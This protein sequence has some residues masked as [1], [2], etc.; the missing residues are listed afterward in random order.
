[1][2]EAK[3][4]RK[5]GKQEI[6]S[7]LLSLESNRERMISQLLYYLSKYLLTPTNRYAMDLNSNEIGFTTTSIR[8]TTEYHLGACSTL[9]NETL[10]KTNR[11]SF[12]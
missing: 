11:G 4:P 10:T 9:S 8:P 7:G 6:S 12:M 1:M 3:L 2:E 5:E